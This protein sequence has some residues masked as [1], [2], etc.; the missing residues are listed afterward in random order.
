MAVASVAFSLSPVNSAEV[1]SYCNDM[2]S[3]YNIW[4]EKYV[5]KDEYV[6][7]Q[8]QFYVWYSEERYNGDNVSVPVTVSEAHG[9]GMLITASMSEYDEQSKIFDGMYRFIKHIQ[10]I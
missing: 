4:K 9:Y 5:V 7:N 2:T 10:A 8:E 6:T 3:F 1:E